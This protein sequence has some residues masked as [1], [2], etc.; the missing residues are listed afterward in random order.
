MIETLHHAGHKYL[1]VLFVL[2][3]AGSSALFFSGAAITAPPIVVVIIGITLGI[4]LE[5]AYFVFSCDLTEA[6]TE[7]NRTGIFVNLF[8]TLA[9]GAASW[10]LFTNAALHVGWAPVD[11]L[12]GLSRQQ[13]A[14]AMAA[15]IVVVI[16]ILSARRKPVKSQTDM[17]ALGRMVTI[18]LPDGTPQEQLR[19]LSTIAGAAGGTTEKRLVP[20]LVGPKPDHITAEYKAI[21][22]N[23]LEQESEGAKSNGHGTF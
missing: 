2:A 23:H 14:M 16:F 18:L 8:Y 21:P 22:D 20:S 12:L 4:A 13:W 10:F 19:L 6:I 7:G 11:N 3:L 5:W 1:K 17:Q 15:L 9:G